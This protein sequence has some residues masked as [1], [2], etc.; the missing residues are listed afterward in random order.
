MK[1]QYCVHC[2]SIFD[3]AEVCGNCGNKELKTIIIEVQYQKD[4]NKE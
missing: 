3:E 4:V 1:K 2:K